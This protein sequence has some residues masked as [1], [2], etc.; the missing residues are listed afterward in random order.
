MAISSSDA[1]HSSPERRAAHTFCTE[2]VCSSRVGG[3]PPWPL[4]ASTGAARQPARPC[5]STEAAAWARARE[6]RSWPVDRSE[7]LFA[8]VWGNWSAK[9]RRKLAWVHDRAVANYV[10]RSR[11]GAV[12]EAC[13]DS[14]G[15]LD[16]HGY[17]ELAQCRFGKDGR[18]RGRERRGH[19]TQQAAK[20]R[21][22]D[23]ASATNWS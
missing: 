17:K 20:K 23:A 10:S 9:C 8:E 12:H 7:S 13:A 22:L 3:R 19:P 2:I 1:S 11:A 18:M 6:P 4:Y 5:P 21:E 16:E 15:S 14:A